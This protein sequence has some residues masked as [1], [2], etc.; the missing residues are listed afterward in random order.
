MKFSILKYKILALRLNH[1]KGETSMPIEI[2]LFFVAMAPV[3]AIYAEVVRA[4][5]ALE[6]IAELNG[7]K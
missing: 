2:V 4:R 5:K 6:K 7:K 1:K 3:I